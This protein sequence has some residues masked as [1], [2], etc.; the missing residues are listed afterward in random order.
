MYSNLNKILVTLRTTVSGHK[1]FI[2]FRI[3]TDLYA[4]SAHALLKKIILV[5]REITGAT[6]DLQ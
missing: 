5:K 6:V 3:P 2:K 1:Y 4:I